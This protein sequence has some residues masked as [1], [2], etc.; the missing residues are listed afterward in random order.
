MAPSDGY[1]GRY[2]NPHLLPT[3]AQEVEHDEQCAEE[4]KREISPSEGM[5]PLR[6]WFLA[7]QDDGPL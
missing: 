1:C 7:K 6:T 5:Q 2:M 4:A 3:T